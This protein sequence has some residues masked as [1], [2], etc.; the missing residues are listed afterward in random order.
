MDT[1]K[2]DPWTIE[3]ADYPATGTAAERWAFL[4]RYALLAPSSHN[5]Q[6][7]RFTILSDAHGDTLELRADRTRSLPV[8]DPEDRELTISCGAALA[9]LRLTMRHFGLSDETR[10]LPDPTDS[11]LLAHIA[12]AGAHAPTPAQDALFRQIPRR[13]TNRQPFDAGTLPPDLL[14]ALATEA[15]AEGAWLHV[16]ATEAARSGIADLIAEGDRQQW[17]DPAFRHELASWLHPARS[18]DGLAGYSL[19]IGPLI[20][21]AFDLGDGQAAT[22]HDLAFAAPALAVLGTADDT[23]AAWLMAGQ[24]LAR[25]LLRASAADV[26]ASFLNQPIQVAA[27]RPRL[28][29][30]LGHG[31]YP[32]VLL[33]LGYGSAPKPA[34]RRPVWEVVSSRG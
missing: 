22:D 12:V 21:R 7:W 29:T 5:T 13:H 10:L 34:P 11:D 33:R 2:S 9:N 16:V 23:P 14:V 27:L 8:A 17:D 20:V 3:E 31:G 15:R 18:G 6:P 28:A 26:W 19:G 24:A 32:Q 25:V 4:L 1:S 30:L